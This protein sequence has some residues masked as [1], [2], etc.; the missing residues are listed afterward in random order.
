VSEEQTIT[1]Q[2]DVGVDQATAFTAFT[3]ELD[4]WWV[5]GPINFHG[6]GQCVEMRM[7]RR[8]GGRLL[9]V[10]D[11]VTADALELG[12]I[13]VWEPVTRVGWQSSLDDVSTE[14]RFD[15]V[16]GGTRVTVEA[17]IPAGGVDK[18]GTSWTRVVKPWFGAWCAKRDRVPHEQIDIARL[19]LG[20]SYA[21][22][23]AAAHWLAEVFGFEPVD[24]LP[25]APDPLP[26]GH[27]GPPW[28]EFHVGNASIMIFKLDEGASP[29]GTRPM[30]YMPWVYVD[31]LDAHLAQAE[32]LG[33][34]IVERK[35]WPWLASYVAEDLEGN[36]WTIVQGRPTM[37]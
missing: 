1:S 35:P 11:D 29:T 12:R 8:V 20:V 16:D 36:R 6:S 13:T 24:E 4:L 23:A 28:I 25:T 33:A 22:P 5:R 21:R 15:P 9:E 17:R 10:Y 34:N 31:D 19:A 7:E 26:E 18:G 27:H 3:E 30:P 2:V 32:K 14:V 37:R